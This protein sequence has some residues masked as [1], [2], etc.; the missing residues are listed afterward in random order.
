L[1]NM[2][3]SIRK[4]FADKIPRAIVLDDNANSRAMI[5]R[6]MR[7]RGYEVVTCKGVAEFERLWRP[8]A[9]DVVIADWD[10]SHSDRGDEVLRQVRNLDWDVPFVLVSGKLAEEEDRA[11]VLETLLNSSGARFVKRGNGISAVC[12][13]AEDLIERRDLALLKMILSLRDMAL[14]GVGIPTT[15]GTQQLSDL[16]SSM[17]AKPQAS[18]DAGRPMAAA[19]AKNIKRQP[20]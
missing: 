2:R 1:L 5:A 8:G 7:K 11:P 12:D 15:S 3:E 10:L 16:L 13:Q 20:K 9:F 14:K 17:V 19:R 6:Q 4:E 18:H